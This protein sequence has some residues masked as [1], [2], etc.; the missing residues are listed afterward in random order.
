[1]GTCKFEKCNKKDFKDGFCSMHIPKPKAVDAV[2]YTLVLGRTNGGAPVNDAFAALSESSSH[3]DPYKQ[4]IEV[5]RNA[6]PVIGGEENV[7][8]VMCLHDTQKANNVSV[9]YSWNGNT[10]TVWGLGSHAGGSGA[11]NNKYAMLWFD[12]KNKNWTRPK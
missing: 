9:W 6:G 3:S 12:G 10:L 5:I 1:M 7:H 2:V 4:R 8:G 11:G